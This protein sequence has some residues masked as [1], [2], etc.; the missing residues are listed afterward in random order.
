MPAGERV[1]DVIRQQ[2][3]SATLNS[4]V[5]SSQRVLQSTFHHGVS[6]A[7]ILNHAI[8]VASHDSAA[9][10]DLAVVRRQ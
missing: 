6:Q 10:V 3:I 2:S 4:D 5:S 9:G 8:D 7:A 1:G